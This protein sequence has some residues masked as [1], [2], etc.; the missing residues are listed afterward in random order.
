MQPGDHSVSKVETTAVQIISFHP[1][2]N[3]MWLE[4]PPCYKWGNRRIGEVDAAAPQ[5]RH[6][7]DATLG[8][9]REPVSAALPG[10]S[11]PSGLSRF[12]SFRSWIRTSWVKWRK[13]KAL[14]LEF[15][16]KVQEPHSWL[17]MSP[18]KERYFV[19]LFI[20]LF[21]LSL[22]YD[23][24][25]KTQCI[26]TWRSLENPMAVRE[27]PSEF[28]ALCYNTTLACSWG[29]CWR[30]LE[31]RTL[32]DPLPSSPHAGRCENLFQGFLKQMLAPASELQPVGPE[33]LHFYQLPVDAHPANL[34]S[35]YCTSL[36]SSF[37]K[38]SEVKCYCQDYRWPGRTI[39]SQAFFLPHHTSL[40][41]IRELQ[42]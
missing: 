32:S 2:T 20:Y 40:G 16:L 33:H 14:D 24:I 19:C 27:E 30:I 4:S 3:N 41:K 12:F 31:Q 28:W 42:R 8:T 21:W 5:L 17:W 1:L 36:I 22:L 15:F 35:S 7:G 6:G 23:L 39:G 37:M 9:R 29:R 26:G 10:R 34:G 13:T 11:C 18:R 38:P 25:H